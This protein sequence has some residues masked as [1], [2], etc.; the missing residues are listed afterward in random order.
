MRWSGSS[1]GGGGGGGTLR[2][3]VATQPRSYLRIPTPDEGG[4]PSAQPVNYDDLASAFNVTLAPGR[5]F[6]VG[7]HSIDPAMASTYSASPLVS[8]VLTDNYGSAPRDL[9]NGAKPAAYPGDTVNAFHAV[10]DFFRAVP[11]QTVTRVVTAN[12]GG[13]THTGIATDTWLARVFYGVLTSAQLAADDATLAA[14]IA[15]LSSRLQNGRGGAFVINPGPSDYG[16]LWFPTSRGTPAFPATVGGVLNLP[17]GVSLVRTLSV[18]NAYAVTLPGG[19][20]RVDA[21]G[22]AA[23]WAV[24]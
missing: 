18:T 6:D 8:A 10:G 4:I 11:G 14:T 3:P 24:T 16:A 17:G 13:S 1:G 7:Q 12:A 22:L 15:G 9:L 19:L 2:L 21:V 23:S 20:Y 5:T